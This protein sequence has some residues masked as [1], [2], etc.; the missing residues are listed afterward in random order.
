[1]GRNSQ[2]LAT[3]NDLYNIG[4]LSVTPS[5]EIATH[6]DIIDAGVGSSLTGQVVTPSWILPSG[7]SASVSLTSNAAVRVRIA[8]ITIPTPGYSYSLRNFS[9]TNHII[10]VTGTTASSS[11]QYWYEFHEE[12]STT[13]A[14]TSTSAVGIASTPKSTVSVALESTT[15]M[16]AS[17]LSVN[18]P[19][20]TASKLY[21]YLVLTQSSTSGM[22]YAISSQNSAFQYNLICEKKCIKFSDVP[23]GPSKNITVKISEAVTGKTRANQ[24]KVYFVYKASSSSAE[25][26]E[27]VGSWNYGDN[28]DGSASAT[29]AIKA[30]PANHQDY[31]STSMRIWCGT[32]NNNQAWRYKLNGN[33]SWTLISSNATT[34]TVNLQVLS[35]WP[36]SSSSSIFGDSYMRSFERLTSIE[37]NIDNK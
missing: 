11:V 20:T 7:T 10:R 21:I 27:L 37:F 36:S 13:Y 25:V 8:E 32:T 24:I 3:K 30:P 15:A 23:R 18:I 29:I 1:M 17:Y 6:Q 19:Y 9:M 31:Y 28:I 26:T 35:P 16:G 2:Q 22:A 5:D 34:A 4:Y 12:G 14:S 33:S